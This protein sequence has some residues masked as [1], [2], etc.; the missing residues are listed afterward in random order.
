MNAFLQA[1]IGLR[2]TV[3]IAMYAT[4]V[5]GAIAQWRQ[6]EMMHQPD[7]SIILILFFVS[8]ALAALLFVGTHYGRWGT[9]R[10]RFLDEREIAQR[11]AVYV[12]A[13]KWVAVVSLVGCVAWQVGVEPQHPMSVDSN[14]LVWGY[15]LLLTSLPTA[16]LA[17]TEKS[18]VDG[19]AGKTAK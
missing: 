7:Q 4:Y 19:A 3:V 18:I 12:W 9:A 1:H 6:H 16:L 10:P 15:V 11:N 8:L 5:L 14:V 13:Y 17:W 2:R